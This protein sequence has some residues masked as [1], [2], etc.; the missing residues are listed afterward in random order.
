MMDDEKTA[1]PTTLV[2]GPVM[3]HWT[4]DDWRDFYFRVADEADVDVVCV[5]EV[6][7]SKRSPFIAAHLPEVIERLRAADKQVILSTLALIMNSREMQSVRD[8][9]AIDDPGILIEANDISAAAL[10]RGR[11]HTIGPFVNVYNEATL[12]YLAANGAASVC[13]PVEMSLQALAALAKDSPAALEVL[14]FGR[15]P[16]AISARC[17]HARAHGLHK[18]GCQYVCAE[19][20]DGLAVETLDGEPFLA[21]NGVQTLSHAYA[22]LSGWLSELLDHGIRRLR[23]SPH[24]GIDMVMVAETFRSLAD[25]TI[26]PA[27]AHA[28]I[29]AGLGDAAFC[30][31][32]ISDDVGCAYG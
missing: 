18:D 30:N 32:Y 25:G 2:M 20:P 15:L 11:P 13:L 9:A 12:A 5:G 1:T 27:E 28:R 29:A 17:Y 24:A 31:G 23:L 26:E 10:L 6:V 14:V 4:P 21:V 19:D 8:A 7:C 3:F 16:L 22:D